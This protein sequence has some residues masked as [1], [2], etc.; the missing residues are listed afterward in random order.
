M[1]STFNDSDNICTSF[2]KLLLYNGPLLFF[3]S[4]PVVIIMRVDSW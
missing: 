4:P 3:F 1:E 2:K